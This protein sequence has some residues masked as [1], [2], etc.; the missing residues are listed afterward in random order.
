LALD[1]SSER[2]EVRV[3]GGELAVFR[4]GMPAD[5]AEPV[6]ALHGITANSHSW[7]G[8]ARALDGRAALIAPDLRGRGRSSELPPPFGMEAYTR[9]MLAVL[10]R[11]GLDRAVLVGHSLGAYAVA[12]FAADH[13][14][15][16]RAAVLVDGGLTSP[17]IQ[18]VDPQEFVPAFLGPALARLGLTF[19]DRIAYR[20]WW[21]AHPAFA[22]ADVADDDL[23]VYADHDLVGEEPNLC[24]CVA[25]D[26]VRTDAGELFAI[27]EPAHGLAVP[28]EMLRAPRGLLDE[29]TPLIAPE[30]AQAW[31]DEAPE[32][33]RVLEV[34]EVNHYTIVMGAAGA[35]AVA[36]AIVRALQSPA[37]TAG[38]RSAR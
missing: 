5:T 13:P 37:A 8:V 15:R 14:D 16:V 23:A 9:D 12:R 27:G 26:A 21:R 35:G 1:P 4:L 11:L 31:V 29:P 25:R 32:Q 2:F 38:L 28:A 19:P 34:P 33:R 22:H 20:D 10:D 6:L 18:D 7:L 17:A 30:L 24:S 3:L 36:Q